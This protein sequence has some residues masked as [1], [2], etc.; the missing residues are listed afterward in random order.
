V[1]TTPTTA[2]TF[3]VV[4][5]DPAS[6]L[7]DVNI[8]SGVTLDKQFLESIRDLGI[9]VPVVAVR[10]AD[11]EVRVRLGHRRTLAA[12]EVGRTVPVVVVGDEA[13]DDAGQID[14]LVEQFHENEHR[15]GLS[16]T[17]KVDAVQQLSLLGVSPTQI[18]KR[19]KIRRPTVQAA[20]A[21]SASDLGRA[22]LERYEFLTLEQ[23][24]VIADFEDDTEA[25]KAL[26]AAAKSGTF[27]HVAQRAEDARSERLAR[28]AAEASL[29]AQGVRVVRVAE[30]G[31]S[32]GTV[33]LDRLVDAATGDPLTPEQHRDC[34][35]HAA[36]VTEQWVEA[37]EAAGD[38]SGED[39]GDASD[40]SV[41]ESCGGYEW[42]P[43][44]V[45]VDFAGHGH[46]PS[47][48]SAG[49]AVKVADLPPAEREERRAERQEVI[50][51]NRAWTS[52]ETVRRTWLRSLPARK[53]APKGSA[54]FLAM[55]HALDAD[56]L[57][58]VTGR[59][60]SAEL[61]GVTGPGLREDQV[62]TLLA[63]CTES[64]AQLVHL[65][66]VLAAYEAKTD[67]NDWRARS[68]R[69]AR[70]L[71][72]IGGL[73]YALADVERLA[74]EDRI[75]ETAENGAAADDGEDAA[76]GAPAA[77]AVVPQQ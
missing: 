65:V 50:E 66:M 53:N 47:W 57:D 58:D 15:A 21:V 41:G 46:R 34:P 12:A 40:D 64:R 7:V 14:R 44:Y 19:L 5:M 10:T 37:V 25:V 36:Y 71:S 22:A 20:L 72:H 68:T 3:S 8:R 77:E 31:S 35:G 16:I 45:C 51:N 54:A 1:S 18:G 17:D 6:L 73:G 70:Y 67:R 59:Q 60:L 55:A 69:T 30:V 9:L 11:G 13:V 39:S 29:S 48:E 61:L 74:C 62:R 4:D 63:A 76:E 26:V 52:A 75:Q 2:T 38:E 49:P 27:D 23:S 32:R 43:V 24:A 28:E 42:V 33:R 56:I